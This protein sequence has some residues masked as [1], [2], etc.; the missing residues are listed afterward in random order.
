MQVTAHFVFWTILIE[1]VAWLRARLAHR[2]EIPRPWLLD[3][4]H[5]VAD[6]AVAGRC[7]Q[8]LD[9]PL[10]A[11]DR[12]VQLRHLASHG[13]DPSSFQ[14]LGDVSLSPWAIVIVDVWMWTPYVMLI[15]L[16]GLRSIPDY[17]YE[18]AEVDRA[19]N[20]RQ[21]W[22]ITLPMALPFIMLAVLFRGIENFKMFDMVNLLTGGGPGSTTEVASIT[23]KREAFEAW[24]T[25]YSSAFAIILFVAVFGLANIY[26][27][28]LNKVKSDERHECRPF[29]GRAAAADQAHRRRGRHLLRAGHD[30]PAR[31]DRAHLVQ[32]AAR[33]DLLSAE[34]GL[35]ADARG[36]LQSVHDAH[37]P[38]AGIHR[39]PAA[40]GKHV[41]Q[42][43]A[44]AQHGD[45]RAVE[46]RAALRQFAH[47]RLRLDLLR[48]RARHARR[49]WLLALQGAARRRPSLLHP[50]DAHDAAHRRRDPDLSHVPR[51]SAS[52]TPGSA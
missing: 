4:R 3:D 14:M 37:P 33:R 1:T 6:D 29:R 38:D 22:S 15:C 49:L 5:P 52:P 41:R 43:C 27:K 34:V 25:G 24:R 8:F 11:A 23:L 20:W 13:L 21:F 2:Q 35:H 46:L 36:L 9:V 7:R 18:A 48:G 10:P 32:V 26:V 50:V 45:R 19:S 42:A 44:L 17:I 51:S 39:H 31:L 12:A 16:A 40:G 47:H 28:A 30:D